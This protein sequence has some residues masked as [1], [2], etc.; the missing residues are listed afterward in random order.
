MASYTEFNQLFKQCYR[1]CMPVLKKYAT[2][3]QDAEDA[4]TE[5]ITIFWVHW[6]R[7]DVKNQSNI[8]AFICT[9]AIRLLHKINKKQVQI[10]EDTALKDEE[11][12]DDLLDKSFGK[13]ST[14]KTLLLRKA[15]KRLGDA[16]KQLI[17]AK[18]IYKHSYENIAEDFGHKNAQVT[19][20]Q[21]HRCVQRIKTY[22]EEE[23]LQTKQTL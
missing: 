23:Q 3:E 4:F 1:Y 10:V 14:Y 15:F 2:T 7:G 16:C 12:V 20:T 11:A 22:F 18:Y 9:T 17:T 19:K 6:K 8:P 5:A 13:S 21:T